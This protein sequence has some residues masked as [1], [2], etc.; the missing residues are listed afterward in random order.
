LDVEKGFFDISSLALPLSK[1][2]VIG[3]AHSEV[4]HGYG[5]KGSNE[6]IVF[7]EECVEATPSLVGGLPGLTMDTLSLAKGIPSLVFDTSNPSSTLG[8]PIA[9]FSLRVVCVKKV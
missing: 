6:Q 1:F 8:L 5:L 3:E 2:Y 7:Y 4:Y 9:V